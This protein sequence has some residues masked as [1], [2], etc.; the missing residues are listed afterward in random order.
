MKITPF[1]IV[2]IT[3][4][5]ILSCNSNSNKANQ[6]DGADSTINAEMKCYE[7]ISGID[8]AFMTVTETSGKVEGDLLFKFENKK[9]TEGKIEGEFRGDT[10]FVDYN[11]TVDGVASK[12]PLAFLKK[13]HQLLQGSG[14]ILTYLG[15]TYF[16]NDA[17]IDF[18]KGFV[19]DHVK[20]K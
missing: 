1:L 12:N 5:A 18:T 20:C 7:A 6:T 13:E 14:E 10:L 15:R 9:N 3:I 2:P 4:L 8:S 19:F 16:K 17:E 11:F